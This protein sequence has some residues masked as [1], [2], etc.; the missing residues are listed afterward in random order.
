MSELQTCFR[1]GKQK[2][3]GYD[4]IVSLERPGGTMNSALK[5]PAQ[6]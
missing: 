3:D 5:R 2:P 6:A 1:L 4:G